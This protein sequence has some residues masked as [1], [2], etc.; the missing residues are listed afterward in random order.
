MIE[1]PL[2]FGGGFYRVMR[3]EVRQA[4]N[5]N[6]IQAAEASGKAD[7]PES[8]IVARADLQRLDRRCRIMSTPRSIREAVHRAGSSRP[9]FPMSVAPVPD[10]Q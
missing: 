9:T 2:E 5:V 4:A 10:S 1:N 8:E 3:R 6:G 7:A